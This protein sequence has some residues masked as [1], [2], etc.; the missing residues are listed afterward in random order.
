MMRVKNWKAPEIF[1]GITNQ[2]SANALEF[3]DDV[4]DGARR[5]CPIGTITREGDFVKATISFTPKTGINKDKLVKFDTDKRWTAR[6]PFDLVRT[7]RRKHRVTARGNNIRV[8]AGNFKIYWAFMV[9]YGTLSTGWGGPAH[10]K[11]FMRPPW[12]A[13]KRNVVKAIKDGQI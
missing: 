12:N 11:S 3:M 6:A 2:A 9:E 4:A 1:Q 13:K 7:I 10:K 8:Y 5:L